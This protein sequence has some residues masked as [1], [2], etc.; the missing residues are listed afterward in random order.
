MKRMICLLVICLMLA[1]MPVGAFADADVAAM[2]EQLPTV[3][4]FQALD[5]DAQL[6]AYNQVQAA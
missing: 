2:L 5:A 4:E 1:V 3:E 6:E